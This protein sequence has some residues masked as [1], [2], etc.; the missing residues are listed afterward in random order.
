MKKILFTLFLS[1][2]TVA[3]F[4]Q[5]KYYWQQEVEYE[6]DID[7]DVENHQFTGTQKLTYHNNSPDTLHRVFYHLYFNA[8]QPNSMMD[9]RSRTIEDPDSRVRDRIQ[10]LPKDEIGYH[11]INS[12]EQD[13]D[14]VTYTVDG[15]ILEVTLNEPILPGESTV[16]D[17]AFESRVPRHIRRSGWMNKEGVEFSMSQWY[18]KLSEYD[19]DGWHPNP[20][21]GREFY[22]VWGSFDVSIS[23]DSSYV[24]GATGHLQNANEIGH[25][26]A[27][28]YERPES[29]KITWHW[30]ADNVHDFMWGADPDFKHTTTQV[31]DG[32]TLHFLYQADTV[33]VNASA[34]SQEQLRENW[35]Q[36]P[37]YTAEA[38]QFMSK[39]YG[40]YPY[41]KFT[42]IQ[43]GDGGMEYPMAT[44][45]T[46]NRSLRSLVGVTVHELVHSWYYGVLATNESRFPWMDEGFTTYTSAL[47]MDQLFNNGRGQNPHQGSYR[48]YFSIVDD[49]KQEALDTHADHFH[50]NRAYGTASYSTGAVFLNQMRYIIGGETFDRGIKRYFNTWKFK[51]PDGRDFLRVM[52]EE[53]DMVLD[54]YYQ[55]FIE[56]TKHIDYGITSVISGDQSTYVTLERND[57]MPMPIDLV[58]TYQDGSKELFYIPLRMMRGTKPHGSTDIQRTIKPDWPWVNPTYT[59]EVGKSAS[60]IRRIEIDPSKQMADINRDNNVIIMEEYMKQFNS[61]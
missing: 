23:I 60:E 27:E 26:Y 29:R 46:G 44:L 47:T 22:G 48:S 40:K 61:Q 18:P 33:A 55:Y 49:S 4:G 56:S 12:L 13:G 36:L 2:F 6:M 14:P 54:W 25:G 8:F 39:N 30:Q 58:V 9:V 51:H 21:I 11:H 35:E 16:F 19:E 38:F 15:T 52:E 3:A 7:V 42:V 57:L 34:G 20:Y 31:P 5:G 53:S 32:P 24:M 41:D 45:I 50:T 17:M 59:L 28:E 43:G 1:F 10:Q 37:E